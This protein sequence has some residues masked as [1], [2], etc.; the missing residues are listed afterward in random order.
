MGRGE[1]AS[2]IWF[3]VALNFPSKNVRKGKKKKA[4]HRFFLA[5]FRAAVF[6]NCLPATYAAPL[7]FYPWKK[8]KKKEFVF[9]AD[10]SPVAAAAASFCKEEGICLFRVY[11][12]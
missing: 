5:T 12:K 7:V 8:R 4:K 2:S 9:V 11:A 6:L 1:R 3:K 10:K